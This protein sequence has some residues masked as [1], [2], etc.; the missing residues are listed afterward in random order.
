MPNKIYSV[1]VGDKIY[2]IQGDRPPTEEDV[3]GLIGGTESSPQDMSSK[4]SSRGNLLDQIK[5][6][7]QNIESPSFL[8]KGVGVAQALGIPFQ[9][10]EAS[11]SNPIVALQQGEINPLKLSGEAVKGITG[12]KLGQYGDV[13]RQAD[14]PE[15]VAATGGFIASMAIP[16]GIIGGVNKRLA[17]F[18]KMSD[19]AMKQAGNDI[20]EATTKAEAHVG[21]AVNDAYKPFEGLSLKQ[22]PASN[23][24]LQPKD[25]VSPIEKIVNGLPASLSNYIKESIGDELIQPTLATARKVKQ[26]IGKFKPGAYG[27]DAK[28]VDILV[29][30]EAI[31]SGYGQV[32][33]LIQDS[34]KSNYGE[35]AAKILRVADEK[36]HRL[37]KNVQYLKKNI[38]DSTLLTPTKTGLFGQKLRVVL[39]TAPRDAMTVLRKSCKESKALIEDA[40]SAIK[41]FNRLQAFKSAINIATNATVYGG[42][43]GAA[44]GATASKFLDKKNG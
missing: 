4:I 7:G 37:T 38:V 31:N 17:G 2:D 40:Y 27:K 28:G 35:K 30:D 6:A 18:G 14:L 12:Q 29:S 3:A 36:F 44:G 34:V 16:T 32:A 1:K 41:S 20:I 39:D 23:P 15:P 33:D 42:A 13:L 8:K 24:Y 25:V 11:I 19:K 26:L 10:L 22:I 43:L 21:Q 9:A 5:S